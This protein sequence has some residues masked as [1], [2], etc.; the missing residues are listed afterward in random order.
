[1]YTALIIDITTQKAYL[2]L[3][4]DDAAFFLQHPFYIIIVYYQLSFK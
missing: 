3:I 2:Y 4:T 1:M